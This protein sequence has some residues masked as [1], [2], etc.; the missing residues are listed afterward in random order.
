MWGDNSMRPDQYAMFIYLT[1]GS[2]SYFYICFTCFK[3]IQY[4]GILFYVSLEKFWVKI[5]M[6]FKYEIT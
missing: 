3:K 1:S 2:I 5:D 6:N 4:E